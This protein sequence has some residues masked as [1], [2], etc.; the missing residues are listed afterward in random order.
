MDSSWSL[1]IHTYI[2]SFLRLRDIIVLMMVSHKQR[3]IS[4]SEHHWYIVS[5]TKRVLYNFIRKILRSKTD[6]PINHIRQFNDLSLD[7][8][9]ALKIYVSDQLNLIKFYDCFANYQVLYAIEYLDIKPLR[10]RLFTSIHFG[11]ISRFQYDMDIAVFS[12]MYTITEIIAPN[13]T[14][15][16]AFLINFYS[17]IEKLVC[18][19]ILNVEGLKK[20]RLRYLQLNHWVMTDKII[21][22]LPDTIESLIILQGIH[23]PTL[24]DQLNK[25]PHL[26]YLKI[27]LQVFQLSISLNINTIHLVMDRAETINAK[28]FVSR[29]RNII[30]THY[31][32]L[33]HLKK[34]YLTSQ[35]AIT[36]Q[37]INVIASSASIVLPSCPKIRIKNSKESELNFNP[38]V[39]Y[40]RLRDTPQAKA[41]GY[42]GWDSD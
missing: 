34:L 31:H 41:M 4:L 26:N 17:Q 23:T 12:N 13:Y 9:E 8:P 42:T 22:Y 40:T 6:I 14:C 2:Y 32:T 35:D 21:P 29:I 11:N 38:N 3:Q 15:D 30:V 25:L 28:I 36:C 18:R 19:I 39:F 24:F 20:T 1:D 10:H 7:Y 5:D 27:N 37:L 16:C 33:C